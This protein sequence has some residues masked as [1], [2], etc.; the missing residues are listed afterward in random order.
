MC[1]KWPNGTSP[2]QG[3]GSRADK[4]IHFEILPDADTAT[5]DIAAYTDCSEQRTDDAVYEGRN[6]PAWKHEQTDESAGI[7]ADSDGVREGERY[8]G[9]EARDD[10]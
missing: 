2:D 4:T 9:S 10:G 1:E 8:H 3:Q 6:V 5:G 7:A